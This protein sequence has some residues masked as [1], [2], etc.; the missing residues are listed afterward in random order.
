MRGVGDGLTRSSGRAER[1][2]LIASSIGNR[3]EAL[4]EGNPGSIQ[5]RVDLEMTV[6]DELRDV[7]F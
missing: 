7:F 5:Y 1:W 6:I 4:Y 3:D 2:K